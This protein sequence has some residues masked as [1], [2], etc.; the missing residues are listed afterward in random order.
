M[1]QD[2]IP[3][4]GRESCFLSSPFPSILPLLPTACFFPLPATRRKPSFSTFFPKL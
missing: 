4:K 2:L 1:Q 3:A